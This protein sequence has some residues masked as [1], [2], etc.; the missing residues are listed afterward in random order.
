VER[1]L[2]WSAEE[3][4]SVPRWEFLHPDDQAAMVESTYRERIHG[5]GSRYDYDVRMLCR[6]GT[7]RWTRW[8]ERVVPDEE[9]LY[10]LGV[11]I[12]P[13]TAVE[14]ERTPVATSDANVAT[15]TVVWSAEL[16]AV[17][18]L[19]PDAPPSSADLMQ[20]THPDDRPWSTWS[21]GWAI[22][23]SIA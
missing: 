3:L 6:D 22:G 20:R 14:G 23:A 12:S 21:F 7:D 16:S 17:F 4:M 9:L 19:P 15:D 5:P 13:R 1:V 10:E 18:D 2:G 8:N 11:E